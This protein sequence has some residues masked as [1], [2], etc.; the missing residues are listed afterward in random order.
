MEFR[1]QTDCAFVD[2]VVHLKNKGLSNPS[3]KEILNQSYLMLDPI[4]VT[5][6]EK[7]IILP[8]QQA[9]N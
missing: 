1:Q 2:G 6:S 8:C 5:G 4:F 7:Q 3:L 9:S